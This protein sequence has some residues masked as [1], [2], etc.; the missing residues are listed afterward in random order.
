MAATSSPGQRS[1][2]RVLDVLEYL[3]RRAQPVSSGTIARE[4]RVPRSTIYRVLRVLK[5]R[6]FVTYFPDEQLWGLGIAAFEVGSGYL[7]AD[8]LERSARPLLTRLTQRTRVTSHLAILHGADV[9]YLL[10]QTTAEPSPPLITA[11]GVRL[12]AHLTAVGRAILCQLPAANVRALLPDEADFVTRTGVGPRR[13][14]ELRRLLSADRIRGFS[15]EK[16]STTEHV[17]CVAAPA[18]DHRGFPTASIGVSFYED[19]RTSSN[20]EHL[21][22]PI[23]DAAHHLTQRLRGTH[24]AAPDSSP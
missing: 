9:L 20:V 19:E 1:T 4:C 14:S 2:E 8:V 6:N 16:G 21:V 22:E 18:F 17:T 10:K 13:L 5:D 7:R 23:R 11:V 3:A 24:P 12:P 15:V